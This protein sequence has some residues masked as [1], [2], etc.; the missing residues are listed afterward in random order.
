M[1]QGEKPKRKPALRHSVLDLGPWDCETE[2]LLSKLCLCD[3]LQQSCL[4]G[5]GAVWTKR[6]VLQGV[7]E[8]VIQQ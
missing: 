4:L 2:P 7:V 3:F 8:M 1:H 6:N 5:I